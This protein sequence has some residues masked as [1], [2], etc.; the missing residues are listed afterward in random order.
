LVSLGVGQGRA[1][2]AVADEVPGGAPPGG[3]VRR[4]LELLEV[5]EDLPARVTLGRAG[6]GRVAATADEEVEVPLVDRE[7]RRGQL[8]LGGVEV[9]EAVGE[10]L[11]HVAGDGLL[12][13]QGTG[14][15][16]RSEGG[17]RWGPAGIP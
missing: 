10:V 16:L 3:Q 15:G 17:S 5:G 13:R 7:L 4:G 2:R 1:G 14:C 11:A 12:P 6:D 8:A 9:D